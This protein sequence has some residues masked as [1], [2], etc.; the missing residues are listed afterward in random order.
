MV[1]PTAPST[2]DPVVICCHEVAHAAVAW[3]CGYHV[4]TF[5]VRSGHGIDFIEDDIAPSD[6]Y[7]VACAGKIA[8][9]VLMAVREP[10][11]CRQDDEARERLK[12]H[13]KR[14]GQVAARVL[15]EQAE[16]LVAA[17]C[18]IKSRVWTPSSSAGYLG[19]CPSPE[20]V[21][22][23]VARHWDESVSPIPAAL[24]EQV[25]E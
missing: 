11:G 8:E 23:I 24:I 10:G 21:A 18:E 13:E 20:D 9:R 6:E 16:A 2:N 7:A 12:E 19:T 14:G 4:K 25:D 5:C 15:D 3:S 22:E 17:A 1:D